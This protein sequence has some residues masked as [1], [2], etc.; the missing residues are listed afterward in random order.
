MAFTYAVLE[1]T[2]HE[3]LALD[4]EVK[5]KEKREEREEKIGL[6]LGRWKVLNLVRGVCL[7]VGAVVAG[8]A[9][10]G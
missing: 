10:L 8:Y 7:G 3:M 1:R 9:V 6:L 5:F 4:K 2:N